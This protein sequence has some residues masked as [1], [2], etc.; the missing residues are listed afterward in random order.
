M[1]QRNIIPLPFLASSI[2]AGPSSTRVG[3]RAVAV[4]LNAV[5][6]EASDEFEATDYEEEEGT[7]DDGEVGQNHRPLLISFTQPLLMPATSLTP[8][9]FKTPLTHPKIAM[10]KISK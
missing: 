9:I 1:H 4:S 2:V 8:L 3:H 5:S 10:S 6:E 7:S